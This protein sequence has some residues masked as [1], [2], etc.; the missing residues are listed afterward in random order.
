LNEE[1]Y[2]TPE[3]KRFTNSH[4]LSIYKKGLKRLERVNRNDIVE[5]TE[6]EVEGFNSFKSFIKKLEEYRNKKIKYF[7]LHQYP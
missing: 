3:G 6:F 7:S 2:V 4:V 1:G 5:V